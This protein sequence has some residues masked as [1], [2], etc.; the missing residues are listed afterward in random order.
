MFKEASRKQLRIKTPKGLLSVEQLWTL[1]L[2]ELDRTAVALKKQMRDTQEE[3]FLSE[4]TKEDKELK[5]MFDVTFSVLETLKSEGE[6]QT[7]RK[8]TREHNAKIDTLISEKKDSDLRNM[9]IDELEKL[10]Q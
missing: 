6:A 1:T 10:R 4:T 8:E 2:K 7:K 5:L 9:S 3:S